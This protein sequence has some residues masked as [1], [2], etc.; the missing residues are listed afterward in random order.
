MGHPETCGF[1]PP[2]A[3]WFDAPGRR[4][5]ISH[6]PECATL[7]GRARDL[8]NGHLK[9]N[10]RNTEAA[11]RVSQETTQMFR[12]AGFFRL[13]QPAR[14]GG[15]EYGFTPFIDIISELARGCPS[16][17]WGCSLGAVHQWLVGTFP[18]QA[19]DDVWGENPEAI[20]C[21]SYAPVVNA[22]K[23][24]G[25][26]LISGKWHWASNI[27]NS[28][29]A[30]V[31]V[32]FPPDEETPEKHAGFLL[33]PRTDWVVDDDWFTAGQAGTGSKT[34]W[35][36]KP[37]FVPAYRKLTFGQ[38]SSNNPP[39]A[40]VNDN[41]IYRIPF[42]SAVPVCLVAPI[43][44]AAQGAIDEFMQIAG[45]HVTRGAVSG[46]G[47]KLREFFPVQSRLAESMALLDAARLLIYRD[48]AQVEQMAAAGHK[49]DVDTRIRNRRDHAF[50]AR[51]A[52]DAIDAVFAN[53]GGNGLAL[54][55]SIQRFW[56]DGNAIAKHISLNWDAVSSMVGQQLLG[57]EPRGQY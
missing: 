25:G 56:R 18:A 57:L 4:T 53:V 33:V 1:L 54:D 38:A 9:E 32:F 5:S 43:L 47:G 26:Y 24:D 41:P 20:I 51:M 30:V 19:Q 28:E 37:A 2:E 49:I 46:G 52:R 55:Q 40:Q 48:T 36:D 34:V 29:W 27:D 3:A 8:A 12:E 10:A 6:A 44:G 17:A 31:G 39:G 7:L 14:F 35:I 50:A 16:S 45:T 11:R 21:G 13:M 15:Y 42:L 23:V 22:E